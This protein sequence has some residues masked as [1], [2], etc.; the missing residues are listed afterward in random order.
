MAVIMLKT[1]IVY[2]LTAQ[3][4]VTTLYGL[5]NIFADTGDITALE[6]RSDTKLY[7]DQKIAA[8][9]AGIGS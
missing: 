8:A 3:Q 9:L 5:N 6:Y 7:I 2:N 4:V 1:P